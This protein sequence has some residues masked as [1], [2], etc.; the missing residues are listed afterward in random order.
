MLTGACYS[1]KSVTLTDCAPID[2]F[3]FWPVFGIGKTREEYE[4]F[5]KENPIDDNHAY[6]YLAIGIYA[7][8]KSMGLTMT[9]QTDDVEILYAEDDAYNAFR[10]LHIKKGCVIGKNETTK[11]ETAEGITFYCEFV[12]KMTE[13]NKGESGNLNKIVI[14]G[15][16]NLD[17]VTTDAAGEKT[18]TATII[19][20]I[21]DVINAEPG[22]ITVCELGEPCFKAKPL[23]EYLK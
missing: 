6:S 21:P 12:S 5:L 13:E 8:I 18:T 14:E 19:N 11:I 17:I 16:P 22:F 1:V 15:E 10:D 4:E 23:A 20:R 7:V 2:K 9:R 3:D